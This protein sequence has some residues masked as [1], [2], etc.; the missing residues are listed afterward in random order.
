MTLLG[1]PVCFNRIFNLEFSSTQG[2]VLCFTRSSCARASTCESAP[3]DKPPAADFPSLLLVITLSLCWAE[4]SGSGGG[5]PAFLGLVFLLCPPAESLL[6]HWAL[7]FKC[8][9]PPETPPD[10]PRSES[11]QLC[12]QAKWTH[13]MNPHGAEHDN[14]CVYISHSSLKFPQSKMKHKNLNCEVNW[15]TNQKKNCVVTTHTLFH[16]RHMGYMVPWRLIASLSLSPCTYIQR[17]VCVWENTNTLF[18]STAR[19]FP[20]AQKVCHSC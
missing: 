20:D 9:C 10:T 14:S 19:T 1:R 4:T 5:D 11:V 16:E 18:Q 7:G 8:S 6:L 13:K 2:Q 12:F 17:Y 3:E 15:P